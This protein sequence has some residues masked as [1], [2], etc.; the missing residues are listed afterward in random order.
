MNCPQ[1]NGNTCVVDRR[2]V[3]RRRKCLTCEHRFSTVE[4]LLTATAQPTAQEPDLPAKSKLLEDPRTPKPKPSPI[5]RAATARK[6]IEDLR[7]MYQYVDDFELD[8]EDPKSY[9]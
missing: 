7:D 3:R 8:F 2:G 9:L 5:K 4:T 1:C 6:K